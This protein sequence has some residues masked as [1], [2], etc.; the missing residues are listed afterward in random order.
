MICKFFN[1][2]LGDE[3]KKQHPIKQECDKLDE[4]TKYLQQFGWDKTNYIHNHWWY[5]YEFKSTEY[6]NYTIWVTHTEEREYYILKI[7]HIRDDNIEVCKME[8]NYE[9]FDTVNNA[10][11]FIKLDYNS[12]DLETSLKSYPQ[13]KLKVCFWEED[14]LLYSSGYGLVC[15]THFFNPNGYDDKNRFFIDNH[16][17]PLWINIKMINARYK[18]YVS[19]GKNPLDY[20]LF[21]IEGEELNNQDKI[22]YTLQWIEKNQEFIN[23]KRSQIMKAEELVRDKKMSYLML[24][25]K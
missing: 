25:T 24:P 4:L 20:V 18:I 1:K 12:K 21:S 9:C 23:S 11:D 13:K 19:I 14:L 6:T 16:T 5:W 2:L 3:D 15:S 7:K 8:F 17:I 10:V 22:N